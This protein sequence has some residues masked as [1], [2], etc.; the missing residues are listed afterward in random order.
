MSDR[1]EFDSAGGARVSLAEL[2]GKTVLFSPTEYVPLEKNEAGEVTGGGVMTKDFG[3]KDVVVTD[4][5][6]LNGDNGPEV[7]DDAMIFN[8]PPIAA[9]KRRIG[10]KYLGVVTRGAEKV[11][12]NYPI[13]LTEPTEADKQMAR[14]YLAGRAVAAAVPSAADT[15][16]DPWA[17]K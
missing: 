17:V 8:G 5:V 1:D 6:V 15:P 4:M 11:K 3:R 16:D 10:R 2:V 13:L 12:G 14:D 9:L 7:Y